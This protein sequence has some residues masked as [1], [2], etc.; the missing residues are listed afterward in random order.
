M[1]KL[2][3]DLYN[4]EYIKI[5]STQI[6]KVYPDFDSKKF[7][8]DVF[9][10]EFNKKELKQRMRHISTLLGDS[11][12][13]SYKN[14][15]DILI[16]VFKNISP[17]FSLQNIIFQDF[18]EVYGLQDFHTS[19]SALEVFTVGSTSEFAI[20]E[21][22][23]KYH[24]DTMK[25]M[26]KWA[27]SKNEHVRRL[28]SEGCRPRLPW[29]IALTKFKSDPSEVIKILELLKSDESA[30]V[31]KSVANSLNDISKDNP[32]IFKTI[33]SSW[34]GKSKKTD[35]LLKH[36]C[37]THLKKGDTF[38]LNIFGYT[39]RNDIKVYKFKY[40]D[41]VH[42]GGYL[43]FSF[44]L[45]SAKSLSKIRVEYMLEFLRSNKTYS[46]K[47]FKICEGDYTCSSK[48]LTKKH[49]FKTISTRKYYAGLQKISIIVNGKVLAK[50]EFELK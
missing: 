48:S 43:E 42:L 34:I 46:K 41:V 9:N 17:N 25:Q 13:F 38:I 22:I 32:D 11:L 39:N 33:V 2:L 19:M 26:R 6:K 8:T 31:R 1:A 10:S 21:F 40:S 35:A 44:L 16:K 4:R 7:E 3:K 28:S 5:V 37:R 27:L 45:K 47:V 12:P 36:G 14:S 15:I 24:E 50:G 18:V 23:I 49:S 29:S 30:Y 20:R